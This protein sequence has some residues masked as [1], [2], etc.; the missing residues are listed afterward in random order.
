MITSIRF[1]NY[2]TF[3]KEVYM[4]F[5]ADAQI[6]RFLCNTSEQC[7]LNVLKTVCVY[8]PNNTGKT[9]VLLALRNLKSL[10]L[11][12]MHEDLTNSFVEDDTIFYEVKYI[13]NGSYYKYL[14]EYN[15]KER[16]YINEE[17]CSLKAQE[18]NRSVVSQKIIAS[19]KNNKI[20]LDGVENDLSERLAVMISDHFPILNILS[21]FKSESLNKARQDYID[22]ANSIE[23]LRP[24]TEINLVKTTEL[25]KSDPEGVKFIKEFVKNCDLH[26]D[27]FGYDEDIKSDVDISKVLNGPIDKSTL[28]FYSKHKNYRVPSF[29]FDSVGTKKIIAL[30]GYIYDAL[31]HN[32]ILLIDEIDSSLHHI[33]TRAIVAMFNNDLNKK[34]QLI[35]STHDLLLMDLKH[36]FRKDQIFLTDI[37][38]DE[39]V[40]VPLTSFPS[41]TENG[42][43][44]NEDIIDHYTKGKFGAIPTADLFESL[45]GVYE[46]EWWENRY[47]DPL[48]RSRR[49]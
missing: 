3:Y 47:K 13:Q 39:S 46:D 4:S 2:K 9:C 28:S 7:G 20:K 38:E 30:S 19:R 27:D 42:I 26:I 49:I 41:N 24:D 15:C 34:S 6:K 40:V 14:V 29:L 48:R 36:I 22:F 5:V 8:G 23:L 12:E 21:T 45:L 1:K 10:M 37:K 43:R 44:G 18:T 31:K 35:F 17:L 33:L 25:M 11:N 32:K 16:R